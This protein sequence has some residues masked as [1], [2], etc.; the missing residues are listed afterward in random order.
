ML[1]DGLVDLGPHSHA[2]RD[3]RGFQ[4]ALQ[5][6]IVECV[7]IL[8]TRCALT[9]VPFAYPCGMQ[10]EGLAGPALAAVARHAGLGCE[11]ASEAELADPAGDPFDSGRFDVTDADP[12]VTLTACPGGWYGFLRRND[13]STCVSSF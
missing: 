2:H 5:S 8:R 10:R 13:D 7:A 1:A 4:N 3:V 11:L 12:D 6:D 9:T